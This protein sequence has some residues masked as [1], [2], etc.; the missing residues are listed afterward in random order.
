MLDCGFKSVTGL[1]CPGCGIQRSFLSLIKGDLIESVFIYPALIP[2]L[3]TFLYCGLHLIFKFK[4][5]AKVITISFV[6]SAS[7]M[8]INYIIKLCL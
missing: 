2:F 7:V 3:F 6:L 1:D 8:I 5:G 4:Q